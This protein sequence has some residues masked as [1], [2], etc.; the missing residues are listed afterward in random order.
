[1]IVLRNTK[2][3]ALTYGEL[4]NNFQEL[5]NR[6]TLAWKMDGLEPSIREGAG[7]PAELAPFIGGIVA[8]SYAPDSVSE[9]FTNWDLPLD[10]APGTD[11][12]LAFHWS[13]GVSTAGGSVRWCIEYTGATVDGMFF[14]PI[15]EFYDSDH[16]ADM[17]YHHHQKVSTP[18]P[19]NQ[20][21]QNMRFLIRIYRDGA[22]PN[23]TFPDAAFLLGVDFYYQSDRFGV[24]SFIPPYPTT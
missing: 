15:T 9:A 24:P 17:P 10:W 6:T 20:A 13:P 7:N 21:Q 22:H 3:S 12:Y 5:D 14:P 16:M 18:F 23:D 8:Y 4:D 11:L 1:M 19:G 2:G